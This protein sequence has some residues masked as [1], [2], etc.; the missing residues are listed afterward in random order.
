ML[1]KSFSNN[2]YKMILMLIKSLEKLKICNTILKFCIIVL[3]D[4]FIL[5]QLAPQKSK[6]GYG[7]GDN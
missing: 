7:L 3:I 5:P 4:K 2:L 1:I 6:P